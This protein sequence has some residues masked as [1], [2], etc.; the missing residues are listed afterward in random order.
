MNCPSCGRASSV[1]DSRAHLRP[2]VDRARK[3]DTCGVRW[4]TREVVV[5]GSIR[6]PGIG[7]LASTNGVSDSAGNG[8]LSLSL[9]SNGG[10]G[11]A[12]SSESALSI[13]TPDPSQPI[14]LDLRSYGARRPRR[15][16]TYSPEFLV[17]WA[18]Y[19]NKVKKYAAAVAWQANG[20]DLATVL[21]ALKWQITSPAWTKD[22]GAY[23]PHAATYVNG[24]RWEDE[25]PAPKAIARSGEVF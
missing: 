11:G 21:A 7:P 6:P 24:R 4:L 3:C 25:R 19:P 17:F 16:V 9:A 23:V 18:A 22:N 20:P 2:E 15:R 13:R 8:V 10:A 14:S 5:K 1:I 12:L